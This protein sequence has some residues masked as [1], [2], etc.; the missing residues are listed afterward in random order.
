MPLV[1]AAATN[2]APGIT[3][4]RATA[5][6]A[7]VAPFFEGYERL[8]QRIAAAR[9]DALVMVSS[10]HIQNLF[11]DN[12]PAFIIG[13]G[14]SF[15]GPTEDEHFIKIPRTTVPGAPDLA[16]ALA[17]D[18]MESVDLAF[19]GELALD[20][21]FMVPLHFLTPELDV[22]VVPIIVN[23]MY[24]PFPKLGRAYELGRAL[25]RAADRQPLRVGLLGTGGLSHWP[26]APLSGKIAE[27]WDKAFLGAMAANRRDDLIRYTDAEIERDGGPGGHEIRTWIAVAGA[28]EGSPGTVDFYTP[29]PSFAVGGAVIEMEIR[30]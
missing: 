27:D 26:A 11:M 22:P 20:H 29:L 18:A 17:D 2:H 19:S 28:C 3:S 5:P 12:M 23:C 4:R 10:D 6:E 7:E 1:F 9:L 25:R 24:P 21:G 13:L 30:S 14:A 16:A 15:R 8:R